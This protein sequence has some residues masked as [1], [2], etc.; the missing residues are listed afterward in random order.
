VYVVPAASTL[1]FL[2]GASQSPCLDF[3]QAAARQGYPEYFDEATDVLSSYLVPDGTTLPEFASPSYEASFQSMHV[4]LPF[5]ISDSKA[6]SKDASGGL[7]TRMH[8]MAG[9]TGYSTYGDEDS[10]PIT[11]SNTNYALDSEPHPTSSKHSEDASYANPDQSDTIS[12]ELD[13]ATS[14]A[15]LAYVYHAAPT[16]GTAFASI[17]ACAEWKAEVLSASLGTLG[18]LFSALDS[19]SRYAKDARVRGYS[20]RGITMCC[21]C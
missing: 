19:V 15:A 16:A 18:P 11:A 8:G 7:P 1:E 2:C 10:D 5:D 4:S 20:I 14:L 17:R 3:P 9:T 12:T 21:V 6:M 13:A